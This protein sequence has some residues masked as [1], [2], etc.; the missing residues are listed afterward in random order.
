MAWPSMKKNGV[1]HHHHQP[2]ENND[3]G[4]PEVT[5]VAE[6][7]CIMLPKGQN[8]ILMPTLFL[9]VPAMRSPITVPRNHLAMIARPWRVYR[10]ST[11]GALAKHG[12]RVTSMHCDV[13]VVVTKPM[14][15][16]L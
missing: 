14:N 8:W 11:P 5:S 4:P 7:E 10:L 16:P 15:L 12:W 2:F 1:H 13:V 9:A 3:F 6:V